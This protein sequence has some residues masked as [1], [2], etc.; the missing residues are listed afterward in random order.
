MRDSTFD[1][2]KESEPQSRNLSI[3]LI[4]I[5]A[6]LGV[7]S[8]HCN[9]DRLDNPIAFV[10]SRM[11]GISIPLFFM[12]SGYLLINKKG[13][14]LYSLKKI[15]GILRFVFICSLVY[16]IIHVIHHQQLDFT[17]ISIYCKAFIEKGPLW[18]F[19]YLGAMC[20]M[21]VLLPFLNWLDDHIRDFFP[22]LLIGLI[23]IDFLIF[24]LTYTC[25]WEYDVIQ[26]FRLWNWLTFFSIG[27]I[28]R[29]YNVC[30]YTNIFLVIIMMIIFVGF[31]FWSKNTIDT[32]PH[33]FTT[34]ICIVY[35]SVVF[36]YINT[37]KIGQNRTISL[38]SSLFLPVYSIHYFIIKSYRHFIDGYW[39]GVI[40]PVADYVII[41]IMTLVLCYGIMK[42][43]F[44]DKIF[45]I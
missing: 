40:T 26:T 35:A 39:G 31:V 14:F 37:K 7:I 15:A 4:K 24:I 23:C 45:K 29:K 1:V 10:L 33:F 11:A 25:K 27:A 44:S 41:T 28:F 13:G 20:L 19:W 38:L 9:M 30:C 6:M 42:I 8:L 2:M 43:P 18:M 17:I 34:P 16:W 21:Y 32:L 36:L 12:V 22:I 5:V 3:D